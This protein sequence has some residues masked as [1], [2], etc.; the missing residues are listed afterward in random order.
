MLRVADDRQGY[1]VI[2]CIP[3]VLASQGRDIYSYKE[4]HILPK[5]M[6][7]TDE[8]D[9]DVVI[10]CPFKIIF[11]Q[12]D[13]PQLTALFVRQILESGISIIKFSGNKPTHLFL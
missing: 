11:L 3:N 2:A 4:L 5:V 6:A 9:M 13:L 7:I 10:C 8:V 1:F 12:G